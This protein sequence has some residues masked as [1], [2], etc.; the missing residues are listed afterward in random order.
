MS[1]GEHHQQQPYYAILVDD[2]LPPSWLSHKATSNMVHPSMTSKYSSPSTRI[3]LPI[4]YYYGA[5]IVSTDRYIC[6]VASGILISHLAHPIQPNR[7]Y[8]IHKCIYIRSMH[9]T[10]NY[11]NDDRGRI[12][13]TIY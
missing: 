3:V 7:S 8:Y 5:V 12:D 4:H 1:V 11:C 9:I 10:I 2:L 6:I 13:S